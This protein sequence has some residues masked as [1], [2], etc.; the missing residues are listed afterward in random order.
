M[1]GA[2]L[3]E[4]LGAKRTFAEAAEDPAVPIMTRQRVLMMQRAYFI[5][6]ELAQMG[7][8]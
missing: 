8:Q 7:A 5:Q 3:R 1:F 4:V 2:D 6:L